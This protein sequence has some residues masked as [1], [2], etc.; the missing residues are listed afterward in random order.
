M[1]V[2]TKKVAGRRVLHFDSIDDILA[3]A[4]Q[5]AAADTRVIGNWSQGQ[6]YQHLAVAM[7]QSIDGMDLTIPWYIRLVAPLMKKRFLTKSLSAGFQ[8]PNNTKLR[9]AEVSTEDGLNA[10]HAAV[11][12]LKS[13]QTRRPNA[14]L[15]E[16]S[17]DEWNQLHCRH[18]ELHMSFIVPAG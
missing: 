4:E 6:I 16:L 18:A 12:R 1:A 15:G 9:P 2:S 3:D 14:I 17:L 8:L 11:E 10:L 5:M 7:N 13:E